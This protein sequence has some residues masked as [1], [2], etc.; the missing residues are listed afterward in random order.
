[1]KTAV[2]KKA[3]KYA[4]YVSDSQVAFGEKLGLDLRGCTVSVAKA[5]IMVAIDEYFPGS[6]D[7]R[8]PTEKQVAFAAKFGYDISNLSRK[9]ADV[10]VEDLMTELN[11][12]AIEA[13]NL[14]PGVTVFKVYDPSGPSFV[15]SS[16]ADDGTVYFKGR[17]G[18]KAWARNLRRKAASAERQ[19]GSTA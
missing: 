15:I 14:A 4:P 3:L 8:R 18:S 7:A 10:V 19:Q 6:V 17:Q 1:M 11:H 12:E 5:R 2:T 9:V 13:E 16:I